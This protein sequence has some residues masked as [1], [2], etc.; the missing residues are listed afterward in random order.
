MVTP[1]SVLSV[2]PLA[3]AIVPA[4]P[5]VPPLTVAFSRSSVPLMLSVPPVMMAPFS[6]SAP[7]LSTVMVPPPLATVVS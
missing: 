2:L 6:V 5:S 1:F 7:V 3:V 4:P